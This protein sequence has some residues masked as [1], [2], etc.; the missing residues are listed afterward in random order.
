MSF[1]PF[2]DEAYNDESLAA[3]LGYILAHE[4]SHSASNTVYTSQVNEL[5]KRY[6][7]S[8]TRDES[9]ADVLAVIAVL[10]SGLVPDR[11]TLCSHISQLWCARVPPGYFGDFGQAHP[12]ARAANSNLCRPS[13]GLTLTLTW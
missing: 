12:Q 7:H 2:A 1:R 11:E 3:R 6:P 4:L 10:R 8:S 5:L 13:L 9:F